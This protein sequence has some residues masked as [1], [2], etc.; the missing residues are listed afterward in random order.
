MTSQPCE[1]CGDP[2]PPRYSRSGRCRRCAVRGV[3]GPK[4]AEGRA[5]SVAAA[6]APEVNVRREAARQRT[7]AKAAAPAPPPRPG[8]LARLRKLWSALRG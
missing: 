6:H 4:T 7:C 8:L 2:D 5:R 1:G 3:S